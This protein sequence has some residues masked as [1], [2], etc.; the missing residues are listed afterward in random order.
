MK[1]SEHKIEIALLVAVVVVGVLLYLN[2]GCS[3]CKNRYAEIT[4]AMPGAGPGV[5]QRAGN[6]NG[7]ESA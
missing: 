1:F 4:G 2:R 5:M 3:T 6:A 7:T